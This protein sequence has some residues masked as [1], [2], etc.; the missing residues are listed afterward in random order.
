[1]VAALSVAIA[2]ASPDA[3]ADFGL[4]I[5]LGEPTG[6]SGKYRQ[7]A[8]RGIQ[9]GLAWSFDSYMLLFGDYLFSF[10]GAFG[11]KTRFVSQLSPYIGIGGTMFF[12]NNVRPRSNSSFGLGIRIPLGLEWNPGDPPLGVFV[13]LAPGLGLVPG[14]FGFLQGGIGIRYYF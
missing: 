13:E 12:G 14:T 1:M 3:R 9:G 4:G 5:V 7:S 10:P 8:Q 11:S 2:G 6:I